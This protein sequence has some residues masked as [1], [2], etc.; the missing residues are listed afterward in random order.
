MATTVKTFER[1]K[2][3]VF[4]LWS[5]QLI[6]Y[7]TRL[8]SERWSSNVFERDRLTVGVSASSFSLSIMRPRQP[9]VPRMHTLITFFVPVSKDST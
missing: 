5:T 4:V 7:R 9:S 2:N 1:L 8:S 6:T 3:V